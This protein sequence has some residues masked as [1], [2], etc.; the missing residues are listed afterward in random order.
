MEKMGIKNLT[1]AEEKEFYRLVGKMNGKETDKEQGVK[2]RKPRQSEE[3]F[4]ISNDGAVI[5][6]RWTNDSLDEGRW[7]LGN[8]FFTEESAWLA[9]EKRKVEVELERY[10]KEHN[11]PTLEDSYF[12]LYDEYNEEFDYDMLADCRPQGAVVFT[13][14]QLVFDA[15]EAV[16]KE[17]I[18]KYI[19]GVESEGEE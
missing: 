17:R 11:D 8:V 3:Y 14:K 13:S 16:G 7:E 6:S 12:I 5:Q 2:V 4:Y 1:E 15:I 18:L 19:F 9:R 10:A